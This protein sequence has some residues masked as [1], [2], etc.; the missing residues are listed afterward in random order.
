FLPSSVVVFIVVGA[1]LTIATTINTAFTV[2]SRTIMRAAR[3]GII[4][5][6]FARLHSRFDT[7]YVSILVLGIPPLL[8]FPFRPSVTVLSQFSVSAVLV[9]NFLTA[10]G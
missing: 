9:G 3:D 6:V 1:V 8:L 10:V 2:Y 5:D 4:P 7:P